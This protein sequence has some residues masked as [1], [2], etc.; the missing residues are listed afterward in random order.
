[1]SERPMILAGPMV[2]RVEPRS[3][4]VWVVTRAPAEVELVVGDGLATGK[5][6]TVQVIPGV[7][8]GVVTATVPGGAPDLA[9][10]REYPYDVR[11]DG[12]GLGAP[13]VLVDDPATAG[14]VERLVYPG[15]DLPSFRLLAPAGPGLRLVHGSCRK[16]HGP[17][18]DALVRLDELLA[19]GDG[20]APQALLLTGDQVYADDVHPELLARLHGWLGARDPER[21]V[22]LAPHAATL[23]PGARQALVAG[24]GLTSDA[25]A[26][27][28]VTLAEFV[29]MYLHVWSDVPWRGSPP[30]A[31]LAGFVAGLPR[32]RRALANVPV[33]M[34]FDDHDCT[35]DWNLTAAWVDA[36]G[37]TDLGRRVVRNALVAYALGQHWGNDPAAFAPGTPGARLLAAVDGW[38][39]RPGGIAA[40]EAAVH[41]PR[42]HDDRPGP[43]HLRWDWRLTGPD[44]VVVAPDCRTRRGWPAPK[45]PPALLT[46]EA[47]A[48]TFAGTEGARFVLMIAPA[49]VVGRP[50]FDFAQSLFSRI[51]AVGGW[52]GAEVKLPVTWD[53][54]SWSLHEPTWEALCDALLDRRWALVLSG[55]VHYGYGA[56]LVDRDA[57]AHLVNFVSS[58][59]KNR[60]IPEAGV[61]ALNVA[62]GGLLLEGAAPVQA[63]PAAPS[64]PVEHTTGK[65]RLVETPLGEPVAPGGLLLEGAAQAATTHTRI[66]GEPHLGELTFPPGK[67]RQT[68]HWLDEGQPATMVTEATFLAG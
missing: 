28:L 20:E 21:A 40:V 29:A 5:R 13:G 36:V 45:A 2:R 50:F 44:F 48:E 26:S 11:V 24:A 62:G 42:R 51:A 16:P 6:R 9:P 57:G 25:A 64:E 32:V 47:I 53:C 63:P 49:P 65:R 30:P 4:S 18:D 3:A 23:V 52:I 41:V 31:D 8:V 7:H 35:D 17:G 55:D 10:G 39:G 46:P 34:Q 54:E 56:T 37:A 38:G 14:E 60:S 22:D 61:R 58:S 43:G 59:L 19:R 68:L 27:H 67:V 15:R 66:L 1:M 33:Y 12:R